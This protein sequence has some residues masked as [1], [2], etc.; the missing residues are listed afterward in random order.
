MPWVLY[1]HYG[2]KEVLRKQ[3]SS[4]RRPVDYLETR[5]RENQSWRR[6][7]WGG[8]KHLEQFI[9]DTGFQWGKWLRASDPIYKTVYQLWMSSPAIA[10]AYLGNSSRILSE[11]CSLL[12]MKEEPKRYARLADNVRQAWRSAFVRDKGARIA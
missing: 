9:L 4:M 11:T 5:A 8:P 3:Y 7:L 10:T 1:Q 12:E 2:D 6:W